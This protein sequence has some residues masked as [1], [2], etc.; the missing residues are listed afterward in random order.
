MG[1]AIETTGLVKTFGAQ[2]AVDGIDLAVPAGTVYGV[3]G[4]NGA[5]KT[6]LLR[7]LEGGLE[8]EAA[9]LRRADG[10]VAYLSQRLDL[11]DAG[12]TVVENFTA[13]APHRTE[14]ERMNLLARFL[15][16]GAKAHLPVGV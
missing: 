12:R 3:L 10:R 7:L 2:R 9:E 8:P 14:A 11:L 6:T 4:P 15:F 5:G 16:R 1:L 13:F